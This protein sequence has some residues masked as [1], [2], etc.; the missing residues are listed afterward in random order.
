MRTSSIVSAVLLSAILCVVQGMAWAQAPVERSFEFSSGGAH[1]VEGYGEWTLRLS[2]A[3]AFS[4]S[5]NVQG[6]TEDCGTFTLAKNEN[7]EIWRLIDAAKLDRIESSQRPG[8]PDEAQYTFAL[9][10][11]GETHLVKTW[12]ND[13]R[14]NEAIMALV[15]RIGVLIESYTKKKAVLK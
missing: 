1:H 6:K 15:D 14:E 13:A 12:L 7:E 9:R 4:I 5:H 8:V 2:A 10:D 11:G 3:G